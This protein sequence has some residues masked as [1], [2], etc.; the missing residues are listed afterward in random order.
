MKHIQL[1]DKLTPRQ[2]MFG[3]ITS[4]LSMWVIVGVFTS[5]VYSQNADPIPTLN[6][7][8]IMIGLPVFVTSILATAIFTWTVAQ[9]DRKRDRKIDHTER[10]VEEMRNRI[11]ELE[12]EKKK[13]N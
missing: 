13:N 8:Q 6:H 10:M 9:Y 11:R 5:E 2:A 4:N 7:D 3:A 12:K 1:T